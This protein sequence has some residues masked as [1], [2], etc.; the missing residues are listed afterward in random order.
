MSVRGFAGW[1]LLALLL[2]GLLTLPAQAGVATDRLNAFFAAKDGLRA[3]F[4][5]TVQ[6]PAFDQPEVSRGTL[7]LLRPN[8]FRWD[9]QEPY[10]Q[11]IV[12]DGQRLWLYDEELEQVVVKPLD[13]ALGDTPAMLLSGSGSVEERFTLKEL[14][15]RGNGL[16]WVQLT[17]KQEDT[18][19]EAV[20]LGF[21]AHD[22]RRME[23]VDGFGQVTRMQFF[24]VARDTQISPAAFRFVPPPGVDVIGES[25]E[26]GDDA[27]P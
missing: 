3:S 16:T 18:G 22:L 25:A 7:L 24:D 23:L 1:R 2:L 17:P 6:A 19:F 4:V 5:Q 27:R 11:Q 12:A 26:T 20:R 21:D 14:P 10:K 15:E 9:Y 13:T 8:R